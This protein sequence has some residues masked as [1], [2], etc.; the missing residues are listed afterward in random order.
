MRPNLPRRPAARRSAPALLRRLAPTGMMSRRDLL[1]G[2]VAVLLRLEFLERGAFGVCGVD[3]TG[4]A[5]RDVPGS[6]DPDDTAIMS[7]TFGGFP[8]TVCRAPTA[9]LPGMQV[10]PVIDLV[11]AR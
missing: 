6:D 4:R 9:G 10:S 3:P 7:R 8:G 11:P 1:R 2:F 5:R